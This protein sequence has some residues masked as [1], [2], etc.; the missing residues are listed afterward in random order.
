MVVF[1]ELQD[2]DKDSKQA[3]RAPIDDTQVL[4]TLQPVLSVFQQIVY[5]NMTVSPFA[6]L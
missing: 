6:L 4:F 1:V 5:L 2:V 3:F